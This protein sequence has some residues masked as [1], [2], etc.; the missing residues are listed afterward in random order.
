M[1]HITVASGR[2]WS[3]TAER[4]YRALVDADGYVSVYDDVAGHY[5]I[6]H[7]LTPRQMAYVRRMA[8]RRADRVS[9]ATVVLGRA[10]T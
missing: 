2:A 8:A 4:G 10:R 6:H 7:A 3:Q 9:V 5:T 1:P